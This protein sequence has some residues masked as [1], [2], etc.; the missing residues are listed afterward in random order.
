M[1]VTTMWARSSDPMPSASSPRRTASTDVVG[2]VSTSAGRSASSR[3]AEVSR[4]RPNMAVSIPRIPSAA[5]NVS[6]TGG[7]YLRPSSATVSVPPARFRLVEGGGAWSR[8]QR[9]SCSYLSVLLPYAAKLRVQDVAH[10]V[11][12]GLLIVRG[13][14]VRD[15]AFFPA[16]VQQVTLTAQPGMGNEIGEGI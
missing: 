1:C 4:G 6:T 11:Q 7:V 9:S 16:G 15:A 14:P 2:P 10:A 8:R 13:S 3:Y 5:S 12:N